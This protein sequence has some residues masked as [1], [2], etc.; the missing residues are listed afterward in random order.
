MSATADGRSLSFVRFTLQRSIWI[1]TL[2]RKAAR[3]SGPQRLTYGDV[4]DS[5]WTWTRD[6]K[7]VVFTSNRGG[8]LQ[9]MGGIYKQDI[10]T[11]TAQALTAGPG[12]ILIVRLSPDGNWLIY[13]TTQGVSTKV[14]LMRIRI[15]GGEPQPIL[16]SES[17]AGLSCSQIAGGTCAISESDG[18]TTTVSAV[19]PMK[20]PGAVLFRDKGATSADISPDG[21]HV[22]Y[23]IPDTPCRRVRITDLHGRIEAD[24]TVAGV[25]NLNSLDWSADSAGFFMSDMRSNESRLIHVQR[26]GA[27]QILWSVPWPT[28]LYGIPSPDGR[29]LATPRATYS[30]NVWMVQEPEDRGR[31]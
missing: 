11:E 22:A 31:R 4:V 10:G 27:S 1:G 19:D 13:A 24:V 6:G 21:K 7:A 2:N 30:S 25:E 15:G 18:K 3:L 8:S 20:G 16:V 14:Q 17:F 5:P 9:N 12:S 23:V 28:D 29:Y 26:S